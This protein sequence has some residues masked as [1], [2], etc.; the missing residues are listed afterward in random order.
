MKHFDFKDMMAFG[1]FILSLLTFIYFTNDLKRRKTTL[2]LWRVQVA[3]LRFCILVNHFIGGS[4]FILI[5]F[6][7]FLFV[8]NIPKKFFYLNKSDISVKL[9]KS[10]QI[11]ES[12]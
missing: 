3:F 2:Q 9:Y 4:S 6:H 12:A 11:K 7:L 8:K 5:I 1:M 10:L